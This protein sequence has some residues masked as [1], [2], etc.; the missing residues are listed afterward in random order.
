[1]VP[2]AT[3]PKLTLDGVADTVAGVTPVPL[4][5]YCALLFVALLVIEM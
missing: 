5:E 4:T 2:L 1:V 3:V